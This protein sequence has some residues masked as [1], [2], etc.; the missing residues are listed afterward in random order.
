MSK[1][2]V[3][4]EIPANPIDLLELA[5]KVSNKH[6]ADGASSPLN[7]MV[8]NKWSDSQPHIDDAIAKH[9]AA[10]EFKKKMEEA[11][12]ERDKHFE[13]IMGSVK[14]SRDVL[15]GINSKNPKALG[16]WGYVVNDSPKAK[17]EK[18]ESKP[19]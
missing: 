18:G 4:V 16:N 3:R 11:Y 5:K 15:L 2:N 7:A 19:L 1:R 9:K 12:R 10:E 17:K 13:A 8:D 6:I 14:S